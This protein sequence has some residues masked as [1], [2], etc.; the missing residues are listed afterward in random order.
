M[1]RIGFFVGPRALVE[2]FQRTWTGPS[3][4]AAKKIFVAAGDP[5]H[6]KP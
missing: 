2:E 6:V 4:R 5:S 1:D 3:S